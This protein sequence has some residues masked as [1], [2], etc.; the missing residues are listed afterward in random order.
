MPQ[1]MP[2]PPVL[3]WGNLALLL[4][5]PV[6]WVAPLLR[7]G[8]LPLFG[9]EAIT[10]VS[11]IAELW[12]EDR[13]LATVVAAFALAAPLAKTAALAAVHMGLAGG[14]AVRLTLVLGKLAMADIFLIALYIVVA[15]GVGV[16]RLEVGWGLYLFTACVLAS[17]AAGLWTQRLVNAGQPG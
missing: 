9:L 7:A 15:R 12:A 11:G 2:F 4:L 1:A 17:L 13:L 14:R 3:R 5:F 16:G 10:V 6:S 8:L